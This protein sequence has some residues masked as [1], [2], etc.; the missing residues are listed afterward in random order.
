MGDA[1]AVALLQ[2][3]GFTSDDFAL[4]HPGGR[5]GRR[6]LLR[7]EDVMHRGDDIPRIDPA[8]SLQQALLE[9]TRKSLGITVVADGDD[10]VLGVFTD[11][12]LARALER[13][14]DI[15]HAR[16]SDL[17]T[18]PCRTIA[19]QLLAAEALYIMQTQKINA[20]P[21]VDGGDRLIGAFNMHD[22]LRAGVV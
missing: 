6:L 21:V 3:R 11:G 22:L 17:M 2:A 4:S 8:G 20:F 19:P 14:I 15:A 10:R 18:S 1:L 13:R 9:M 16:I 12:D 7:V 5:L